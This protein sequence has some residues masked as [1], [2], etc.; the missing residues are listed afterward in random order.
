L[1]PANGVE[2]FGWE[3]NRWSG[4]EYWYNF[5]AHQPILVIFGRDVAERV[6]MLSKADL[7]SH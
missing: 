7:L 4:G 6:S 3:N 5:N 1:V 2:L